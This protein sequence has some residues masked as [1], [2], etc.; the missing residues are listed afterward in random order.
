MSRQ[1]SIRD[2]RYL[3]KKIF[4]ILV[5][6][7][8]IPSF[9]NSP[10]ETLVESF[11]KT[12]VE[13][14]PY[15]IQNPDHFGT[16]GIENDV[17]K[18]RVNWAMI[19][20]GSV[21]TIV[22]MHHCDVV[23]S[24]NYGSY[25]DISLDL[26]ALEKAF[27]SDDTLLD[28]EACSDLKSGDWLFGRGAADMKGGAA[29]QFALFET[30]AGYT[31]EELALMPSIILLALP[32]EE[33]LS[34]G[35]REAVFLLNHLKALH[36]LDFCLAVNSEPHQRL[37]PEDGVIYQ[38]SIAKLNLFVY[39]KGVMAHAGEVLE[40]INPT[41]IMAEIAA[42]SDLSEEITDYIANEVSVPPT[43]VYLRDVKKQYDIS[44]PGSCYGILNVLSFQTGPDKVLEWMVNLCR[45]ELGNYIKKVNRKRQIFSAESSRSGSEFK[46]RP[47]VMTYG[48]LKAVSQFKGSDNPENFEETMARHLD[49]INLQHPVV[50][51]GFCPPYYPG[52]TNRSP[53]KLHKMVES[54]ALDKWNQKYDSK[55]YFNGISDLS[56]I[57]CS[58]INIPMCNM[59]GWPE[60]YDIP[61]DQIKNISMDCINLG[62]WGKDLH[63]PS[64]RVYKPDLFHCTP[65]LIDHLIRCHG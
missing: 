48:Q 29:I 13:K 6:Y 23:T 61:F 1:P 40:G 21:K 18:R 36:G 31:R 3:E 2:N 15:F 32:D 57:R 54:F 4:E 51:V 17:L 52:V 65:L 34:S 42:R 5:E 35:M 10:G 41:G 38:G 9:T 7:C 16:W 24:D 47:E 25:K 44:F 33:T 55:S 49:S 64:E 30:Y 26:P 22:L 53:E 60:I 20:G 11:F 14:R 46:W 59:M 56:Y 63:K 50:I 58:S 8:R 39:V 43:W 19:R 45:E 12:R 28:E 62:P 37:H 27:R